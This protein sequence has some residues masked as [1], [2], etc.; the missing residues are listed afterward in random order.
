MFK[1]KFIKKYELEGY[2]YGDIT[3]N[4]ITYRM[5]QDFS[6]LPKKHKKAVSRFFSNNAYRTL[7][8]FYKNPPVRIKKN[9]KPLTLNE[10]LN[11]LN[12]CFTINKNVKIKAYHIKYYDH[13]AQCG[14]E[15]EEENL[16]CDHIFSWTTVNYKL[17]NSMY[18][19]KTSLII[20]V[21]NSIRKN[22]LPIKYGKN[23]GIVYFEY[24]G[25]QVSF[26]DPK[27]LIRCKKFNGEWNQVK[28]KKI[29]FPFAIFLKKL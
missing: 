19:D 28:N 5:L 6:T 24:L 26:H 25:K 17:R 27:N 23:D 7:F 29:P 1:K 9:I 12:I 2:G 10:A 14:A 3:N 8:E 21:I 11:K 22:K 4:Y 18:Y 13:C 16:N 20:T 15:T